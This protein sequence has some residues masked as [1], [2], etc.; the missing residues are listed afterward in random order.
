M[1]LSIRVALVLAASLQLLEAGTLT[2]NNCP[3]EFDINEANTTGSSS[4][5]TTVDFLYADLYSSE[6][7]AA[8]QASFASGNSTKINQQITT[9]AILAPFAVIGVAFAVTFIIAICCCVFEKSCPPCKSWKR[10]FT[11]RPYEKS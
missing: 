9:T 6:D 3:E 7:Q 2:T 11:I 4:V 5:Q 1:N 8:L 10:D